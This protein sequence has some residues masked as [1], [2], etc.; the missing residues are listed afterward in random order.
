MESAAAWRERRTEVSRLAQE[1]FLGTFP[2]SVPPLTKHVV[3]NSTSSGDGTACTFVQLTFDTSAGGGG[4][5]EVSFPLEIIAPTDN[6]T[7]P[8][9]M[10]QW[11]HR[12]WA[13]EGVARG[14][15]GVYAAPPPPQNLSDRPEL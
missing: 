2:T 6:T 4:V 11:N 5:K 3:L 14:Y 9:F 13:L 7:R 12:P 1:T 8:V 15:I 10:T